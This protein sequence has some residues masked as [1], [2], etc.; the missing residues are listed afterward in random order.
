[1]EQDIDPIISSSL[2]GTATKEEL[3]LLEKWL[4]KDENRVEYEA[5]KAMWNDTGKLAALSKVSVEKDW[6]QVSSR[7]IKGGRRSFFPAWKIAATLALLIVAGGLL[8]YQ[9]NYRQIEVVAQVDKQLL[10]LPD[11]SRVSLRKGTVIVYP[12]AYRKERQARLVS[13]TAY[14]EI[15]RDESKPFVIRTGETSVEV[16]GTS[17]QVENRDSAVSVI[18]N[19]GKVGFYSRSDSLFLVK[20]QS[21]RFRETRGQGVLV[22]EDADVNYLSWHTGKLVFS[23][24]GLEKVASDLGRHFNMTFTIEGETSKEKWL[25]ADFEGQTH[26]E[27]LDEIGLVLGVKYIIEQDKVLIYAGE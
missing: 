26:T 17:F 7:L 5:L 16:L 1:M 25:T 9:L 3:A 19:S 27:V 23:Q 14:F 2:E 6:E 22:Q 15:E 10:E 20:E 21:G 13:G 12:V 24:A 18:V 8:Y 4:Q 11:G